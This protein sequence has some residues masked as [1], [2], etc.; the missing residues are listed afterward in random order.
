MREDYLQHRIQRLEDGYRQCIEDMKEWWSIGEDYLLYRDDFAAN[1]AF[2]E[3]VL[4][5][6]A[7]ASPDR[8]R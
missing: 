4:V 2:H 8:T 6:D 1:V 5:D 3:Q 7:D